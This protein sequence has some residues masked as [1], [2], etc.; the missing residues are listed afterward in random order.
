ML[1]QSDR[2]PVKF[3][4]SLNDS[5]RS[6]L[7]LA[8]FTPRHAL[9]SSP[10]PRASSPAGRSAS[11]ARAVSEPAGPDWSS[12]PDRLPGSGRP[13]TARKPELRPVRVA[14]FRALLG[15]RV[16][17]PSSS[18]VSGRIFLRRSLTHSLG[19][20]AHHSSDVVWKQVNVCQCRQAVVPRDPALVRAP[21]LTLCT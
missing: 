10:L 17:F 14:L 15:E 21:P 5:D 4:S 1:G 12:S 7:L 20:R 19:Q 2:A 9:P 6:A 16:Y 8:S 13:T 18:R 3:G 11:V